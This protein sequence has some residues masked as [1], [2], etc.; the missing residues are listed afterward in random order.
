MLQKVTIEDIR[1][2]ACEII[3]IFTI[4]II[5]FTSITLFNGLEYSRIPNYLKYSTLINIAI[6][7]LGILQ[8][9]PFVKINSD[10]TKKVKKKY[11]LFLS[12]VNVLS[13]INMMLSF[14]NLYYYM[15]IQHGVDLYEFWLFNNITLILSFLMICLACN[16]ML[17]DFRIFSRKR[18]GKKRSIW[19]LWVLL[20]ANFPIITKPIEYFNI[21]DIADSK[22]LVI[23]SL[24]V[25]FPLEFSVFLFVKKYI[26]FKI[27]EKIM[28]I[29]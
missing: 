28:V 20:F 29:E 26:D 17:N 21:A 18:D 3:S 1:K 24:L 12:T 27:Q 16:L 9:I 13:T 8:W 23:G 19:G 2:P 4:C 6:A 11:A 7:I 22:F 15:G 10:T 25:L 14:T 5:L